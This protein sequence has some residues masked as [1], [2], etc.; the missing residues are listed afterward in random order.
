MSHNENTRVKIPAILH[1]NKLGYKYLSLSKESWDKDTNIFTDIFTEAMIRINDGIESDDVKRLLQNVSLVLDNE[2]L[3]QAFFNMLTATSGTR[4]IDFKNFG[5]NSFHIVTELPCKKDDEEFRPDITLLINGMPLAFI[6]V[7][8]PNNRDGI[9]AERVRINDRFKNKKFRKFINISQILVFSNNMEYDHD[10]VEPIQGAFYSS[11]SHQKEAVFNYFREEEKFDLDSLLK[12]EDDALE[13]FVL[14]D[15]N[16]SA[17]K[18]SPEFLT[19]K[20]SNTPT[21]RILTSLFQKERLAMLLN[22]S[23]AYV[24]K[25][26]GGLEKHI[27]RYPQLF[28]T[29]A[30][31]QTIDKGIKKGIIWHT[32]GSGKTAL[33]FYNVRYLTDYFQRKNIV[34]KFY[35]IVD[36]IDLLNQASDEFKSREL[37]VHKVNSREDLIKDFKSQQ[38]VNNASGKP[39]ITVVNIQKF[40]D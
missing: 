13:N 14:K 40:K 17:I 1:L 6:E 26:N 10:D 18:Y 25:E 19:N 35:F 33:A 30:I 7:K 2:D 24:K 23:I 20:D 34:P 38:A 9:L 4:L 29:K 22:Y 36:R 15:N 3:G 11:T 21:N 28:A 16:L 27:M 5:N 39:E 31:K 12:A 32:Q 8:K 37:I